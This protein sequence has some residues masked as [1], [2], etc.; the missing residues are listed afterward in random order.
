MCDEA[1]IRGFYAGIYAMQTHLVQFGI[2]PFNYGFCHAESASAFSHA[3][4]MP[5]ADCAAEHAGEPAAEPTAEHAGEHTAEQA[6]IP[7]GEY[8]DPEVQFGSDRTTSDYIYAS[9]KASPALGYPASN[10]SS[11]M[12][13]NRPMS[14][15]EFTQEDLYVPVA[16]DQSDLYV[17]RVDGCIDCILGNPH[18]AAAEEAWPT[19]A[20]AAAVQKPATAPSPVS[21]VKLPEVKLPPSI[22]RIISAS[23]DTLCAFCRELKNVDAEK[24]TFIICDSCR[25]RVSNLP[26][27]AC[28]ANGRHCTSKCYVDAVGVVSNACQDCH[29]DGLSRRKKK[30][31]GRRVHA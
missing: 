3:A 20:E 30:A 26:E 21:Y 8:C 4:G 10:C 12:M 27:N 5:T 14:Q 1:Y 11:P 6:R 18:E 16:F 7:D 17:C 29:K 31:G 23:P 22:A 2:Y 28:P 19:L 24:Q 9:N 15:C 25:I 13:H